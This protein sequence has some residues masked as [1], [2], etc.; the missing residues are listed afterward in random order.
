MA[1]SSSI[2]LPDSTEDSVLT[3]HDTIEEQ[4]SKSA[5]KVMTFTICS[6]LHESKFLTY[7]CDYR[8]SY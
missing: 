7:T 2:A 1:A 8:K 3:L 5:S 4:V 6:L